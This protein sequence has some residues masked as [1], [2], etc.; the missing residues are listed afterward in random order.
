MA[1]PDDRIVVPASS[2]YLFRDIPFIIIL[3]FARARVPRAQCWYAGAAF[4]RCGT[5]LSAF[6]AFG[7]DTP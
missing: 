3:S 5:P 6:R 1:G 2:G 7:I 4:S